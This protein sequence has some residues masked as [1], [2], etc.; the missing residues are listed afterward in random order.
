MPDCFYV[1]RG[2]G[3]AATELTRGPWDADAQHASPPAALLGRAIA[4]HVTRDD[5][6]VVRITYEVLRPVPITTLGVT[7]TT[8]WEGRSVWR[9][10]ASLSAGGAEVMR[11]AALLVRT[12]EIALPA[13]VG[14]R[15]PPP[16]P[17]TAHPAPFFPVAW[18]VGYHTGME[19]R[20][21]EGSFLEAGPAVL[22]MR[23]R[24]PL[25]DD[26]QPTPLVRVLMVA[27]TGNGASACLDF[28]RFVFINPDLTVHLHRYP[29]GEWVCLDA[30][31]AAEPT[32]IGLAVA[33]LSDERGVIGQASQSLYVAER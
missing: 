6:Q 2:D 1:A 4:G 7:T 20:F 12:A 19:A 11:A 10:D 14:G 32:G 13:D 8:R 26:E 16:G 23:M 18:D 30:S 22:W 5:L 27:D 29:T 21:V 25:V 9:V 28:R 17:Q 31:T 3:F 33:S 24:R 15:P